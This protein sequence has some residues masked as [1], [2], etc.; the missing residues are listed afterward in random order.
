MAFSIPP[1]LLPIVE[2]SKGNLTSSRQKVGVTWFKQLQQLHLQ[3]AFPSGLNISSFWNSLSGCL[4][5]NTSLNGLHGSL[6]LPDPK[7][8]PTPVPSRWVRPLAKTETWTPSETFSFW[9]LMSNKFLGLVPPPAHHLLPS[10]LHGILLH[11]KWPRELSL[12]EIQPQL[13]AYRIKSKCHSPCPS[14]SQNDASLLPSLIYSVLFYCYP[15][16]QFSATRMRQETRAES[17]EVG[18][19]RGS[20]DNGPSLSGTV[21]LPASKESLFGGMGS[22]YLG[23]S[24]LL[25]E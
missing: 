1:L 2:P 23:H 16:L 19:Q 8:V 21:T 10:L 15:L 7:S 4:S 6:D 14:S 11:V 13:I 22:C 9:F 24:F 18:E 12:T 17:P 20:C 3:D 5:S 25:G